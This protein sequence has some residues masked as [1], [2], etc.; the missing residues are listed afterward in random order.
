M[1]KTDLKFD[2][3]SVQMTTKSELSDSGFIWLEVGSDSAGLKHIMDRH[4]DQLLSKGITK[5]NINSVKKRCLR[6]EKFMMSE[7]FSW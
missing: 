7:K 6:V 4:E 2:S 3:E 1:G 5:Y